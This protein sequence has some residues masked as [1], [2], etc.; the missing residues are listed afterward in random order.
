MELEAQTTYSLT[1]ATFG[2]TAAV[3]GPTFGLI[4]FLLGRRSLPGLFRFALPV[5][6]V[7]MGLAVVAAMVFALYPDYPEVGFPERYAPFL[8]APAHVFGFVM[9]RLIAPPREERERNAEDADAERK[10]RRI[11]GGVSTGVWGLAS[12]ISVGLG[13]A[14]VMPPRLKLPDDAT[15]ITESLE[16]KKMITDHRYRLEADMSEATFHAYAGELQLSRAGPALYQSKNDGC[17]MTARY[18]GQGRMRLESWCGPPG[19]PEAATRP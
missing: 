15:R 17:G 19:S 13:V 16:G 2:L 3:I 8:V 9:V 12:L 18:D 7:V 1:E 5:L 11:V 14:V 6:G 4:G 10:V